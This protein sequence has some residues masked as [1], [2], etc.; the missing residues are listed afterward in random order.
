MQRGSLRRGTRT[1]LHSSGTERIGHL[2]SVPAL[3][4]TA[5]ALAMTDRD[6][7]TRHHRVR[8]G[9]LLLILAGH[10]ILD[11]EVV[12][13]GAG[14]G[15]IDAA[16]IRFLTRATQSHADCSPEGGARPRVDHDHAR[17]ARASRP[18]PGARGQ[19]PRLPA[20]ACARSP[21]A[22]SATTSTR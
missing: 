15:A 13:S 2:T 12:T 16:G 19:R 11:D 10:A 20:C 1:D 7:E 8:D 9:K 21:S 22:A 5:A 18:S 6:V 14:L 17:P 4:T 3:H